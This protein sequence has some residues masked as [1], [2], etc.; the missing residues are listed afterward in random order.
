MRTDT[1]KEHRRRKGAFASALAATIMAAVA[2][3]GCGGAQSPPA[4][5]L[6]LTAPTEGAAV[7]VSKIKVFGT[8]DPPSAAV[9]VAGKRARVTHGAFARWMS[10]RAGVSHIKIV[11]SAAGYTPAD[12]NVTVSSSPSALPTHTAT[13]EAPSASETTASA[14]ESTAR[15]VNPTSPPAGSRYPP[16]VQA[17]LLRSCKNAQGG[18]PAAGVS[19][20]CYVSHLEAH[21]SQSTLEVWERAFLKGEATLPQWLKEAALA[22]RKT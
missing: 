18:S 3:T 14:S 2:T 15:A 7:N 8:V 16:R 22:C 13:S 9:N 20:G 5:H 4:V 12:M 1:T 21:V 6:A 10:L 17:T 11:A 19:C